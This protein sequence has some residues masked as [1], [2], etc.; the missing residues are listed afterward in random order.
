MKDY[1]EMTRCVLQVRDEHVKK[2]KHRLLIFK[3]GM[4]VALCNLSVIAVGVF[5]WNNF[6]EYPHHH[7]NPNI[8][9]IDTEAVENTTE[10][11]ENIVTEIAM[12]T[13]TAEI[14]A[15]TKATITEA[16]K[17]TATTVEVAETETEAVKTEIVATEI[18]PEIVET[19]AIAEIPPTTTEGRTPTTPEI[20]TTANDWQF[21]IHTTPSTD[22]NYVNNTTVADTPTTPQTTTKPLLPTDI[23][24][25]DPTLPDF[26]IEFSPIYYPESGGAPTYWDKADINIKYNIAE[27]G[28]SYNYYMY[29]FYK[30]KESDIGQYLGTSYMIGFNPYKDE[31]HYMEAE[32]YCVKGYYYGNVIAITFDKGEKF[33]LYM[34]MPDYYYEDDEFVHY[35]NLSLGRHF[36]PYPEKY[37]PRDRLPISK[38]YEYVDFS[39]LSSFY[40]YEGRT[41]F[42]TRIE[43]FLGEVDMIG[44]DGNYDKFYFCKAKAYK[45][46]GNDASE[47]IAITFDDET[48]Y[49]YDYI[50]SRKNAPKIELLKRAIEERDKLLNER[51][52]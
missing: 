32:A 1:K 11:K 26:P 31:C 48:Y 33:H 20:S 25:A 28:A 2:K 50:I 47:Q 43:D 3:R 22:K 49:R 34:E 8:I 45:T 51:N 37:P 6:R 46:K 24:E 44:Y 38:Q 17:N 7:D 42:V 40:R 27:F 15:N 14:S 36:N 16:E 23:P 13:V 18:I 4:A 21:E 30:L 5:V 39:Q 10:P 41:V 9:E 12:G 52:E 29:Q 35:K 19:T